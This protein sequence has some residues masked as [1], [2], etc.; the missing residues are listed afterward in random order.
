ME[1]ILQIRR[2]FTDLRITFLIRLIRKIRVP[3]KRSEMSI[4]LTSIFIVIFHFITPSIALAQA[5]QAELTGIVRDSS[6]AGI[7]KATVTVTQ[8]ETG[9]VTRTTSGADGVYTITNL[10]P[11]SYSVSVEANSFRRFIQ[12]GVR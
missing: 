9:E 3:L 8:T 5:G 2:I 10:H 1:R 12:E 4:W 7:A 6:G 11:G